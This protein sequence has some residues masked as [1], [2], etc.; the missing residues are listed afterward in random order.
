[1]NKI[2]YILFLF[3]LGCTNPSMEDG[4]SK[5]SN[6]LAELAK[7]IESLNI[8]KW[9]EDLQ[10]INEEATQILY[11]L[12]DAEGSWQISIN[13]IEDI[14]IKLQN[15][16]NE[17]NDWAT[18]QQMDSLLVQIQ[19]FGE[20]IDELVLRA[21]YDYDGVLNGLDRCPDTPFTK[22]N[23][24]DFWGCAP[25]EIPITSTNSTTTVTQTTN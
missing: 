23:Q 17:S 2:Y 3:L 12:E 21:D 11:D 15:I 19:E 25:G 14:R 16:L 18:S 13:L 7:A 4:M 8:P 9:Q 20:G 24:V 1:M 6:S 10:D 22:I 5:L